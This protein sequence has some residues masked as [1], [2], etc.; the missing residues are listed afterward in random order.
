MGWY[1][2]I[3]SVGSSRP[4]HTHIFQVLGF[5]PI[6]FLQ[7]T[8]T[9]IPYR[10]FGTFEDDDDFRTSLVVGYASFF[11]QGSSTRRISSRNTGSTMT[12]HLPPFSHEWGHMKILFLRGEA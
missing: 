5:T 1:I 11:L 8:I 2:P 6:V 10:P 4:C 7:G 3:A 9:N 12:I